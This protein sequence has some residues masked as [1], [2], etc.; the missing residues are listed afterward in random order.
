MVIKWDVFFLFNA[1]E[2]RKMCDLGQ[3][4]ED[5]SVRGL[6]GRGTR[7]WQTSARI[8]EFKAV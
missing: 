3:F 2:A 6:A 5:I 1:V 4:S 7:S 8:Q